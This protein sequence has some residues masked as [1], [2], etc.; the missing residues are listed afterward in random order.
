MIIKRFLKE[1]ANSIISL[2][3]RPF[4]CSLYCQ[5]SLCSQNVVVA[6]E[7]I[8]DITFT[9]HKEAGLDL[10]LLEEMWYKPG[11]ASNWLNN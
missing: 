5:E 10:V 9:G 4:V 1:L 7:K 8:K 2:L 3:S 6:E 11:K